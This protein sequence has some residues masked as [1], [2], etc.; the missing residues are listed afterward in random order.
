VKSAAFVLH[1]DSSGPGLR[2]AFQ[3]GPPFAIEADPY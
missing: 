2:D 3:P 1:V